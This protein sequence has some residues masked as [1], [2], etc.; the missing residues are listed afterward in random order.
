MKIEDYQGKVHF[1]KI[2]PLFLKY[3]KEKTGEDFS[4]EIPIFINDSWMP[5]SKIDLWFNDLQARGVRGKVVILEDEIIGFVFYYPTYHNLVLFID[6]FYIHPLHRK[7]DIAFNLIDSFS[8]QVNKGKIE[9][10]GTYS[11]KVKPERLLNDLITCDAFRDLEYQ[12]LSLLR[13]TFDRS[14]N[15]PIKLVK[16]GE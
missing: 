1:R 8:N 6:E 11:N 2:Y 9:F 16:E 7:Q 10:Y 3:W 5:A 4:K 14:F 12:D 13:G 15:S